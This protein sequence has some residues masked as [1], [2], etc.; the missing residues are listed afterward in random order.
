MIGSLRYHW[1]VNRSRPCFAANLLFLFSVILLMFVRATSEA[2]TLTP[3]YEFQGGSDGAS[4]NAVIRDAAGNLYGTTIAGGQ[5]IFGTVFKLSPSGTKTI[6]Y[7]FQGGSDGTEPHGKL[8][9]DSKGNL[10]G[11]TEYGGNLDVQCF[12]MPGCGVV[13]RV[14]PTGQETVLYSFNGEPDGGQ[15]LAGL[16]VGP[17][18]SLYGTT[19]GGGMG[20]CN[21][22]TSGCGVVFKIDSALKETVLHSFSGNAD[23][24]VPEAPLTE[25]SSGNLYGST[26][27]VGASNDGTVYKLNGSDL[28]VLLTFDGINGSQPYGALALDSKGNVY[29]TTYSGGNLNYC[30][31]SSGCGV[32]FMLFPDGREPIYPL[33]GGSGGGLPLAGLVRDNKGNLYG[34]TAIGGADN[35]GVL[36]QITPNGVE[37]VLH[38]FTGG[39]DG[40]SP[41]TDLTLDAEGNLYGSAFGGTYGYGMIFKLTP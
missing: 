15:P 9:M 7:N 25:D 8:L 30:N 23:G 13:F 21:Y 26:T 32:V 19:A 3:L 16:T 10:Y 28:T 12:F 27:G 40:C 18:D 2:Q 34:T 24:G 36:F 20:F 22:E 4:P 1:W 14:T 38:S 33:I 37:I 31:S 11:T 35:C 39:T 41:D 17:G 29:G 5:T 6:L